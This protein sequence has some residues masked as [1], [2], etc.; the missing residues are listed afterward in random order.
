MAKTALNQIKSGENDLSI[1]NS[2]LDDSSCELYK[3]LHESPE[4]N[5]ARSALVSSAGGIRAA[6]TIYNCCLEIYNRQT[7]H[8]ESNKCVLTQLCSRTPKVEDEKRLLMGQIFAFIRIFLEQDPDSLFLRN[9]NGTNA[10]EFA[11]ITNKPQVSAYLALL[12]HFMGRDVNEPGAHN[13]TVL[14]I[15]ARKGDDCAEALQQL[16]QLR[17]PG[18]RR[19][20]LRID[21]VNQGRKTPLDVAMAC[22]DLFSTGK[23]RTIYTNVI[24]LFHKAIQEEAEELETAGSQMEP[25]PAGGGMSFRNF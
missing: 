15:M 8:D 25:L 20:L 5:S 18:L 17:V 13:H 21:V 9:K 11:G 24:E 16:L 2:A 6:L 12:Y 22:A 7:S 4:L 19:R 23:S 3:R 1:S 14:H 10:L